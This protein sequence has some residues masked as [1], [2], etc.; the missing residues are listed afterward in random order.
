ML[1]EQLMQKRLQQPGVKFIWKRCEPHDE[2]KN[3]KTNRQE[4][5]AAIA[6][7]A[8]YELYERNSTRTT[9]FHNP[10]LGSIKQIKHL[11]SSQ[12]ATTKINL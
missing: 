8:T 9:K 6:S 2:I 11:I 5:K 3:I 4:G 12:F 7:E 1:Q 10:A